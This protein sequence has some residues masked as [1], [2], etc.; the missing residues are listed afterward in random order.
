LV[1]QADGSYPGRSFGHVIDVP[2]FGKI[3]LATLR[4][5]QSDSHT[6]TGVPRKTLINLTMIELHMGCLAAGRAGLG[7]TVING[8]TQP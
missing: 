2:N 7:N 8:G 4:L 1:N 6:P 3:Y 5:E